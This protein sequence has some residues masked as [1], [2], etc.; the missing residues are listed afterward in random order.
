MNYSKLLNYLKPYKMQQIFTH[1]CFTGW[2]NS[3]PMR[4]LEGKTA[5]MGPKTVGI[6]CT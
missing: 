4:T 3:Q 5:C 1:N 6:L 2:G